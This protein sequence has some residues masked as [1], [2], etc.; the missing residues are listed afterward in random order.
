MKIKVQRYSTSDEST[1]GLLWIDGRWESYTIE[2]AWHMVKQSGVTRI[3]EGTYEV[4][5]RNDGGMTKQYAKRFPEIH[6]GMLWL[7][8]VPE[9]DWVYIHTG[10]KAKHSEGCILVADGPPN[11][12]RKAEGFVGSSGPAYTRIYPPIAQAILDG[13]DVTIEIT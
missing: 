13:E 3:P 10:N 6:Q 2:D 11:D 5:L 9:F 7:R 4:Q 12:N 1:I 8:Q